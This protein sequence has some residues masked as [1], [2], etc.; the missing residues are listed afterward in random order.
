MSGTAPLDGVAAALIVNMGSGGARHQDTV[1]GAA[2]ARGMSV[3]PVGGSAGPPEVA[4]R[5]AVERGAT[6]LAAAGGDG[7]VSAVAA[8]AVELDLPLVVVPCGTRNHFALDCGADLLE[9]ASMLRALDTGEERRVDLGSVNGRYFVN[10]VS[11][12]FYARMVQD[13]R[14]RAHRIRITRRYLRQALLGGGR[15]V[16]LATGVPAG[17]ALPDVALSVLVSN[18]AYSPAS[19]P[20]SALR[21]GLDAGTLWI[22]VLGVPRGAGPAGSRLLRRAGRLLTGR[23]HLA[24]WPAPRTVLDSDAATV[25]AG[26]DG[27]GVVLSTPLTFRVHPAALRV[28]QPPPVEGRTRIIRLRS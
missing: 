6:A 17:I 7:T 8:V 28:L 11:L 2:R 10:N 24:A 22:Y 5:R 12:G 15:P 16:L 19:A 18:N 3:H 13:P 21:A 9:P 27:E 23:T 1:V 26:I 4:A 14:Y 25:V 20:G